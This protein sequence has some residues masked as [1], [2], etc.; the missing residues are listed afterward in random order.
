MFYIGIH[1]CQNEL[2]LA[3]SLIDL[4]HPSP[5]F[6]LVFLNSFWAVSVYLAVVLLGML[7]LMVSC[8]WLVET[9]GISLDSVR[10]AQIAV[11]EESDANG[12]ERMKQ[13][14]ER[15]PMT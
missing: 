10:L 9:K 1:L 11:E 6:Q 8:L 13:N 5:T 12:M 3:I 4:P 2:P 15:A 14:D 7:N